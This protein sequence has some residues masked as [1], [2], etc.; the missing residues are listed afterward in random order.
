MYLFKQVFILL[1]IA[2]C[3]VMYVQKVYCADSNATANTEKRTVMENL[4]GQVSQLFKWPDVTQ[5]P[6]Q[7]LMT[8]T[9]DKYTIRARRT[10]VEWII[11]IIDKPWLPDVNELD[12][13]I[14]MVK[15]EYGSIDATHCE[16]EKNGFRFRITQ[17][18]T[19]FTAH[20][21]GVN[22]GKLVTGETLPAKISSA[23]TLCSQIVRNIPVI[24]TVSENGEPI[25]IVPDGT[26]NVLL[27]SSFGQ[28]IVR[29]CDDGITG[30][31]IRVNWDDIRD[32]RYHNYW[33][34]KMNWFAESDNF[35]FYTLKTEGGAWAA[36][37][38]AFSMDDRWFE[39]PLYDNKSGR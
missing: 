31:A 23:S 6:I 9:E 25:N 37:Y 18:A 7:K 14:I 19:V 32:V 15:D 29:E 33:W 16:W 1:T 5:I 36:A 11:K 20:I 22:K 27:A 39:P 35:S 10:S 38:G 17:S 21:T 12:N 26:K 34:R 28:G 24:E 13:N 2:S 4:P 3:S 8:G 30:E